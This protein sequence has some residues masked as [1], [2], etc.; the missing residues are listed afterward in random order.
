VS[1][2]PQ[3]SCRHLIDSEPQICGLPKCGL[4]EGVWAYT[5]DRSIRAKAAQSSFVIDGEA[6]VLGPD[7]I[8]DFETLYGGKRNAEGGYAFDLL[9]DDGV[10][11][12]D[13]RCRSAS[14]GLASC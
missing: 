12:R 13:K 2:P 14:Y 9:M 5:H 6:V 10:D 7:G 8:C 1:L 4:L 11:M 3:L